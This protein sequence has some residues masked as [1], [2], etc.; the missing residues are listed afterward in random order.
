VSAPEMAAPS[1]KRISIF[2]NHVA[3][4]TF[5]MG[6]RLTRPLPGRER[7]EHGARIKRWYVSP[8]ANLLLV[9][10]SSAAFATTVPAA[11]PCKLGIVFAFRGTGARSRVAKNWKAKEPVG[12]TTAESSPTR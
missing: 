8:V 7:S 3:F 10:R 1:Y 6:L 5:W 2:G 4:V 9:R 11:N 12:D